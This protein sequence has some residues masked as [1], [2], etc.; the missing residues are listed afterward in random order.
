M[1]DEAGPTE[2]E[3]YVQEVLWIYSLTLEIPDVLTGLLGLQ[4]NRPLPRIES[5]IENCYLIVSPILLTI[6]SFLLS[7]VCSYSID[8]PPFLFL[9]LLY[10]T[11]IVLH[12]RQYYPSLCPAFPPR[13]LLSYHHLITS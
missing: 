12:L 2:R 7:P 4:A 9:C 3:P 13:L 6:K 1:N 5:S 8:I 11:S 10:P